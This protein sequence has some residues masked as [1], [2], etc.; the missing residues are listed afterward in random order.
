MKHRAGSGLTLIELLVVIAV[1]A[2]LLAILL[3]MASKARLAAQRVA[4]KSN[5]KQIA[6]AWR[7]YLHDYHGRFYQ[8]VN[9]DAIYGGWKGTMFPTA[10]RPLNKYVGLPPTPDSERQAKVFRCPADGS[11]GLPAYSA[12]GTSYKTNILM[13][14][15]NQVGPL[16][17]S[18]LQSEINKRLI[19]L[20]L[21]KVRNESR[22]L[23]VGDY[24]WDRQWQ[25]GYPRAVV[26]H[27]KCCYYNLAFLDCHVE[28]LKIR[29]GI[30]VADEY[31][32]LP[33]RELWKLACE[34]QVEQPCELCD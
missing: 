6:V 2:L 16:P 7:L 26:W 3:P 31:C 28:F 18:Q 12:M 1:I 19:D 34:V 11:E 20:E 22:L 13:I 30:F 17:S 4:C 21:T 24:P 8:G 14:G 10:K 27:N 32:V 29:K 33:F 5:L 9:A 23:L 25:P 15:Q